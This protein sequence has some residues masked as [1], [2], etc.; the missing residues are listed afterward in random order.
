MPP[1]QLAR[2]GVQVHEVVV[3]IGRSSALPRWQT[4]RSV[5][6]VT[7]SGIL[8]R[9][10]TLRCTSPNLNTSSWD[11]HASQAGFGDGHLQG[12]IGPDSVHEFVD[13]GKRRSSS[14]AHS[15]RHLH[16]VE[17]PE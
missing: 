8:Y 10:G 4:K 13:S 14:I 1:S 11:P 5:A 7:R 16:D 6:K 12:A 3:S 15:D 17:A 2:V 9:R